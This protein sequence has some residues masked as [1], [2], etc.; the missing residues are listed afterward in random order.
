MFDVI[1]VG[2][3]AAGLREPLYRYALGVTAEL[4]RLVSVDLWSAVVW[5]RSGV[6]FNSQPADFRRSS[7]RGLPGVCGGGRG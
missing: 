5:R 4:P 1:I 2:G 6:D 7:A 3:G